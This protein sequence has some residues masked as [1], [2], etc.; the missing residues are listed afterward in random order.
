MN[1]D[2]LKKIS[3]ILTILITIGGA[4]GGFYNFA[5][6]AGYKVGQAETKASSITDILRTSQDCAGRIQLLRDQLFECKIRCP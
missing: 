3:M 5:Y 1:M 2:D 6:N 4:L